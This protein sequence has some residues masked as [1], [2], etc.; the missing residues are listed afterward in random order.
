MTRGAVSWVVR[1]LCDV[2]WRW[3]V[4]LKGVL[5]VRVERGAVLSVTNVVPVSIVSGMLNGASE[6]VAKAAVLQSSGGRYGG[7]DVLTS[8]GVVIAVFQAACEQLLVLLLP[9]SSAAA[10]QDEGRVCYGSS[11]VSVLCSVDVAAVL[12]FCCELRS[13]CP[14]ELLWTLPSGPSLVCNRCNIQHITTE[15]SSIPT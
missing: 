15:T 3:H 5:R 1:V 11:G 6:L 12:P 10:A 9:A 14:S 8:V 4:R 7:C 2:G 13:E